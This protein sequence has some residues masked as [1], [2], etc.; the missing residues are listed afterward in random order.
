MDVKWHGQTT[1]I[2]NLV[3]EAFAQTLSKLGLENLIRISTL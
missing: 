2:P 1:K 3:V